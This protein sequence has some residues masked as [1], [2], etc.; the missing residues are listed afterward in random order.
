[1]SLKKIPDHIKK[2]QERQSR[3]K[4]FSTVRNQAMAEQ[5]DAD[6]AWY[7]K[8]QSIRKMESSNHASFAAKE[9]DCAT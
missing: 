9:E 4:L 1:M 3:E 7:Q 5:M 6:E 2:E 8:L